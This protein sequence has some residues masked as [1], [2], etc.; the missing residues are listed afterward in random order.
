MDALVSIIV[1]VLIFY[2]PND[3]EHSNIRYS[4]QI[5]WLDTKEEKKYYRRE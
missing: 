3:I 1:W 4:F 5:S 2:W